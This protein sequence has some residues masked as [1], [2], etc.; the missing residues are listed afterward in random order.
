[1]VFM[2]L[3]FIQAF[4]I[5]L[6]AGIFYYVYSLYKRGRFSQRDV[7]IWSMVAVMLL[8]FSAFDLFSFIEQITKFGRALDA[9]LVIAILGSY[10]LIF[11]VY[12]RIQETNRQLTEL[13][14]KIAIE[15]KEKGKR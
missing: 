10:G 4:G 15:L 3:N 12:V 11:Q 5:L 14:R 1:M 9:L 7:A 2:E 13:V 8:L 6:S